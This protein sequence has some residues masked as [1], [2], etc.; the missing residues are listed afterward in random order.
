MQLGYRA[1]CYFSVKFNI[2]KL[3]HLILMKTVASVDYCLL[4]SDFGH[5]TT[6]I[7]LLFY[8]DVGCHLLVL[9]WKPHRFI[10]SISFSK[11]LIFHVFV[12]KLTSSFINK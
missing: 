1:R 10:I 9:Q 5:V 12:G 3:T 8:C 7:K 11:H 2:F 4:T 6:A